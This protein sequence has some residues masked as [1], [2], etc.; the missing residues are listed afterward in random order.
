MISAAG[1]ILLAA[2]FAAPALAREQ[3]GLS[4]GA[5]ASGG[6]AN[7]DSAAA[8]QYEAYRRHL[9]AERRRPADGVADAAARASYS[10]ATGADRAARQ[11]LRISQR[12]DTAPT[13]VQRCGHHGVPAQGKS[14]QQQSTLA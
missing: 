14:R 13:K 11:L 3:Q 5:D 4:A 2:A 9:L 1:L 6:G 7:G 12:Q 10:A 8:R